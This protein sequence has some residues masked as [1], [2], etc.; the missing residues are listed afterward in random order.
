[1]TKRAIKIRNEKADWRSGFWSAG[2][3]GRR[4]DRRR[5]DLGR[6]G[7]SGLPRLRRA[8]IFNADVRSA[9]PDHTARITLWIADLIVERTEDVV[10]A[11]PVVRAGQL[12]C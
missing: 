3:S 4:G 1:M 7:G 10:K 9:P 11:G 2:A 5:A 12:S 8:E 6:R